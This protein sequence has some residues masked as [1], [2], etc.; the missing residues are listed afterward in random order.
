MALV[1]GNGVITGLNSGGLPDNSVNSSDIKDGEIPFNFKGQHSTLASGITDRGANNRSYN[2][3]SYINST[4]LSSTVAVLI[5]CFYNHGGGTNHGYWSGN[6]Y[7]TGNDARYLRSYHYDWYYNSHSDQFWIP[8]DP[9]GSTTLNIQC[10][11]AYNN[12]SSNQF[13]FNLR[14]YLQAES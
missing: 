10:L 2:L 3:T 5:E 9:T 8:W 4:N 11:G 7:Q 14:G 13:G 1:L 6:I 12:G